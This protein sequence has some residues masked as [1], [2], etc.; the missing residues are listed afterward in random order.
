MAD[1]IIV[2][3][4]DTSNLKVAGHILS[5]AGMRVTALKSGRLALDYV[6]KNG[7]PDL[8]LLDV[9]MPEMDGFETLKLLKAE[10]APGKEVPVVFLTAE[11]GQEQETRGL[12]SGA[13]DYIKKPFDPEVLLSRVHKILDIQ[14]QMK[15]FARNA[16]TDQLTGFMNKAASEARMDRLCAEETGLL[17][18]LDLDAFKMVNDIFGHDVGDKV[19][20][21]FSSILRKNLRKDDECGRIGGDEF[22]VFLRHMKN[23][24]DLDRFAKRINEEYGAGTREIMGEKM[25]FSAGVSVGAVAVPEY[26]REYP[27]LFHMADQA[28]YIIKKNGKHGGRLYCRLDQ[29]K[30]SHNRELNLETITAILEER[31]EA[32]SAMWMGRDVFGSIYKYM[33]R[34]MDR[35]HSSA[36]RVLL[37]LKVASDVNDNDRA[38]IIVQFR[39]KIRNSLRNS[40]VMMECGENQLFLLLPEIQEHDIDRVIGRLLRKWNESGYPD[41]AEIACEYGRVHSGNAR[42]EFCRDEREELVIVVDDDRTNQLLAENV[43]KKHQLK[44]STLSSG[45]ELLE[46]MKE[47]KPD[48]ILLDIKMPGIDGLETFRRM[49]RAYPDLTPPVIFLTADDSMEA[50][51]KCLELGAVDFVTKPFTPDVLTLRVKHT[52]ELVH[53]QRNLSDAVARKTRENERLSMHVVQTL[54]EA[55]DAK[56]EYTNGHSSRVAEYSREIARRHGYTTKQQEEIYMMGLLHDV[57]KIGVPDAVIN[58]PGKLTPEEYEVIKTHSRVGARILRKIEEMPKLV[59]GARWH[60]ERY[61]GKGYPDGLVGESIPEEAR[62]IAVAD[63][64]DAM[65]SRRSYRDILPQE[66][67]RSEIENGK[68]SQFDPVLADIMLAMIDE[69]P[70]YQNR[71]NYSEDNIS[72]SHFR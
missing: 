40:D 61:D 49:K 25:T 31:M 54:A 59:E 2:V 52:L 5:K 16:A 26:G 72:R 24:D 17:C 44:V 67:V 37:T 22:I 64:Y 36:Y 48:L 32:P 68:G 20:V 71:E 53:L 12:E 34:Y 65:S 38:D 6:Q 13:M 18:V 42:E 30:G 39:R 19:L 1:W 63:A 29:G 47:K 56:D 57:G 9:N 60:H 55:I 70:E 33:V 50:E 15:A 7:C 35:Y 8:I 41:R 45:E 69:D 46:M 27:E 11:D 4:D 14:K 21:M 28:L 58:K 10:M 51:A 43:L 23:S 62:I 66:K 3:D